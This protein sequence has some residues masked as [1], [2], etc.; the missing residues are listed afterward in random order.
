MHQ[1]IS[2]AIA[3]FQNR[4]VIGS[5]TKV[6]L[7]G[8]L[9]LCA[10]PLCLVALSAPES[11]AKPLP[12]EL[13][14]KDRAILLSPISPW[15]LNVSDDRCSLA[16]QFDGEEGPG[17]VLIEQLTPGGRFD[18]I[19]AGPDFA[20]AR[21]GSWFYGG[22][23]SDLEMKTI[24]PLEFRIAGYENAIAIGDA[25]IERSP[26][27][28]SEDGEPIRAEVDP[29]AARQVDRI[30]LQRST[31]IVS[32]ETGNMGDAFKALNSCSRELLSVWELDETV[33]EN[34]HPPQMPGEKVY[35][36]RLNHELATAPDNVGHKSLLRVRAMVA[37]DGSVTSCYHE[38]HIS[39][40][41]REPDVCADIREREFQP[42]TTPQGEAIDSFF[43]RTIYLS[44]YDPWSHRW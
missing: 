3:R 41:G 18:L 13:A 6:A 11:Q 1:R 12:G 20:R 7:A 35:F 17:L 26:G 8:R 4:L 44:S 34:Y 9:V 23:R 14:A 21:L 30:V 27:R 5:V 28:R 2:A 32:F 37:K 10:P 33:H 22:M 39:S 42:A 16:R 43:S 29:S 25:T 40:G 38:Y 36:S 24:S 15:Q 31:V 19:V